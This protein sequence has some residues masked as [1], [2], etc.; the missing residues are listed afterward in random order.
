MRMGSLVAIAALFFAGFLI[1][2]AF[3][4]SGLT[5]NSDSNRSGN[6]FFF[7]NFN[8]DSYLPQDDTNSDNGFDQ[9]NGAGDCGCDNGETDTCDSGCDSES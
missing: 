6:T 1:M 9:D 4:N 8:H 3:K 5:R 7:N 2:N